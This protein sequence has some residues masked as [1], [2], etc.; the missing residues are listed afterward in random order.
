MTKGFGA[1]E[2][3]GCVVGEL[4][5]APFGD[6][7]HA[8]ELLGLGALFVVPGRL[9]EE[10]VRPDENVIDGCAPGE[11]EQVFA[12]QQRRRGEDRLALLHVGLEELL[13]S[14]QERGVVRGRGAVAKELLHLCNVDL[15]LPALAEPLRDGVTLRETVLAENLYL[16]EILLLPGIGHLDELESSLDDRRLC[17]EERDQVAHR[18]DPL[19][20]DGSLGAV[21]SALEHLEIA[22]RQVH[23]SVV[24]SVPLVERGACAAGVEE[25]NR[26][27]SLLADPS[28]QSLRRERIIFHEVVPSVGVNVRPPALA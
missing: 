23:A 17:L 3:I 2:G 19:R 13:P 24:L 5:E 15:D 25:P 16:R 8:H 28:G 26:R 20:G 10:S 12:A 18:F 9:L 11:D 27:L 22:L 21:G 6:L 14:V 7:D 1:F 4:G